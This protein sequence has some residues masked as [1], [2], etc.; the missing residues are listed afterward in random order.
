MTAPLDGVRIIEVG[1]IGPGP[2]ACMMLADHGAQVIRIE[3]TGQGE[4]ARFEVS[5]DVL[6]R[7]REIIAVDLKSPDGIAIVRDLVKSADG[8]VEGFRPGV[9]ERLGLGPDVLLKDNPKLVYGRMTG[10]GQDGPLSAAAGHDINYLALSGALHAIGEAGGRPI[11][12]LNLVGDFGGGSMMLVFGILSALLHV[13][14]GGAGQVVDA[15]I[16]DGSATLAALI[17]G[18]RAS[19]RWD[20]GRGENFLD[21]GAHFYNSY[22]TAD[23]NWIAIG[24]V[25]PQFYRLLSD[26]IGLGAE[27]DL[28][29]QWDRALWPEMKERFAAIFRKKTRDQWCELLEGTDACFAPILD[30]DEAARHPHNQ[31]RTAFAE[32]D[33][34]MQP[35]AAPRYSGLNTVFPVM[36]GTTWSAEAALKSIGYD[37]GKIAALRDAGVIE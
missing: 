15:A 18:L 27:Q 28:P 13:R 14:S 24:P 36:P 2:F 17:W 22:E 4:R 7:S 26:A 16:T 6:L 31:A 10:W 1:G 35:M 29:D 3:R 9:M 5:K 37:A 33:G 23:G 20:G 21:T 32:V 19:G 34:V 12:P 25:E 8:L 11:P 30:F